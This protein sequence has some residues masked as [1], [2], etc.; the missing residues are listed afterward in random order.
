MVDDQWLGVEL[1]GYRI[2]ALIGRGGLV[3]CIGPRS[4]GCTG[5]R[6]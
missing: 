6:R 2:E 3:W 5:R 1:G 4:Y